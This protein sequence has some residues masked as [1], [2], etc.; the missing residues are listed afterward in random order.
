MKTPGIGLPRPHTGSARGVWIH[1]VLAS[2]VTLA[3]FSTAW[4][5]PGAFAYPLDDT[6]IHMAIGHTLANHGVW[7]AVPHAPASASSSPLWTMMLAL[8]Y[9]TP[10]SQWAELKLY[11]PLALNLLW[12]AAL[13]WLFV[14]VLSA[15]TTA[16]LAAML[17]WLPTGVVGTSAIG[18]EH[19]AHTVLQ[20]AFTWQA[21]LACTQAE[22]LSRN[23]TIRLCLLAALAAMA[24]YEA[25]FV[26][27]PAVAWLFARR[28]IRVG[29]FVTLSA[30]LPCCCWD[31]GGCTTVGGCCPTRCC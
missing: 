31:S 8:V 1:A 29:M 4:S 23:H 15:H 24:R 7:G 9:A 5:G 30:T 6:Y 22:T 13:I 21:A 28:Q 25:L 16:W 11:T 10:V 2:I 19:V 20:L 26:I 17:A 14:R 18:M 27:A 12:Q 3:M